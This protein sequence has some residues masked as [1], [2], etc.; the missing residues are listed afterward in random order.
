MRMECAM[1]SVSAAIERMNRFDGRM[2]R[3]GYWPVLL[4]LAGMAPRLRQ[5]F[6]ARPLWMDEA[7]LAGNILDRS[8][9]GLFG[10]LDHAQVAP[11]GYLL[12]LKG[13][14]ALFGA[15][16]YAVRLPSLVAGL[17]ALVLLAVLT[18]RMMP[19]L[20]A[21]VALAFF[22]ISGHLIYYASECK[23]YSVDVAVTLLLLWLALSLAFRER[24]DAGRWTLFAVAGMAAP[25]FSFP[26][27][28]SLAAMAGV[29]GIDALRARRFGRLAAYAVAGALWG[30]SFLALYFLNIKPVQA[31]GAT[32]NYMAEYWQYGQAFLPF[33]PRSLQDLTWF[34]SRFLLFFDNPGG[35]LMT[36][37][38][39]F[40]FLAGAASAW[41]RDRRVFWLVA[42]PLFVGLAVSATGK[43]PFHGRMTLYL[44][45]CLFVFLGEG[46]A[47]LAVE[48]RGRAVWVALLLF[49]MLFATQ[50]AQAVK[51]TLRPKSHHELNRALAHIEAQWQPGDLL[52]MRHEEGIAFRFCRHRYGFTDENVLI[53][54]EPLSVPEGV[55]GFVEAALPRLRGANRV[56]VPRAYDYFEHVAPFYDVLA[57][58]GKQVERTDFAGASALAFDFDP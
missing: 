10:P 36:G 42:G 47:R 58:F 56:W 31:H 13:S 40:A 49:A 3:P 21:V 15:T 5:F 24:L 37:L 43:Y 54:P 41:G 7:L 22:A 11:P 14:V 48:L 19:S 30:V 23:P 12:L 8:S 9:L 57:G 29:L 46:V 4:V 6:E 35:F 2:F 17:L 20:T 27:L 51:V 25:W 34:R 55:T 18:L 39:G 26:A 38:A 53:E 50:G 52:Y 28:F 32:M 33:P 16:E 45:P 44:A 1:H